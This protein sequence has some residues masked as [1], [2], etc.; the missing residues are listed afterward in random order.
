MRHEITYYDMSLLTDFSK[1][2]S[3]SNYCINLL[4]D[5]VMTTLQIAK[6]VFLFILN[7]LKNDFEYLSVLIKISNL[8][9]KFNQMNISTIIIHYLLKNS[10]LILLF[11][12]I[13]I[14]CLSVIFEGYL[15][16]NISI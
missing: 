9:F 3:L 8:K 1:F 5:I 7:A 14:I 4:L 2:Y 11:S 6:C 15:S 10:Y 16:C 12:C 13:S